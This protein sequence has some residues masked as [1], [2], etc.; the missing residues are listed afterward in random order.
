MKLLLWYFLKD[1]PEKKLKT[2]RTLYQNSVKERQW[3]LRISLLIIHPTSFSCVKR[4]WL[5]NSQKKIICKKQNSGLYVKLEKDDLGI[6][7]QSTVI[8]RTGIFSEL[9]LDYSSNILSPYPTQKRS[10]NHGG[11]AGCG[12]GKATFKVGTSTCKTKQLCYLH[13]FSKHQ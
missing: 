4:A 13:V 5:F 12:R 7:V 6:L 11:G 10:G 3:Y 8:Y 2:Q 1:F 9:Q